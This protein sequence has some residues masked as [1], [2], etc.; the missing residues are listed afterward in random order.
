M[1]TIRIESHLIPWSNF[2]KSIHILSI[3]SIS[4]KENIEGIQKQQIEL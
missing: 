4:D 2:W 1:R 3:L